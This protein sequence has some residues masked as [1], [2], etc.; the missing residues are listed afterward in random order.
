L[1]Q[2]E[3]LKSPSKYR[4][5]CHQVAVAARE[6]Q[7]MATMSS[8]FPRSL[9]NLNLFPLQSLCNDQLCI[10]S[11]KRYRDACGRY[12]RCFYTRGAWVASNDYDDCG[13]YTGRH[14]TSRPTACGGKHFA[15]LPTPEMLS[16]TIQKSGEQ[17]RHSIQR[18]IAGGT[19]SVAEY[20][21]NHYM[22]MRSNLT[23]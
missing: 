21:R 18:Q 19:F 3:L 9:L 23:R 10:Y 1:I 5:L 17:R 4:N 12:C 11:S 13:L 14:V 20:R 15:D 8:S 2:H 6:L 7:H 22:S 16:R